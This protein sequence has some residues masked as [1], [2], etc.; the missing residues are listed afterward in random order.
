MSHTADTITHMA[1]LNNMNIETYT[2]KGCVG[3]GK[4]EG[5][6]KNIGRTAT[7]WTIGIL[8]CGIG[9]IILPFFKNCVYCGHNS[10]MN[11]HQPHTIA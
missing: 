11:K 2:R 10:F 8:T 1:Q 4:C 6:S 9:L 3:C 7:L 5:G